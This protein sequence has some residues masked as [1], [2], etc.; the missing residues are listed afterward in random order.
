M[1][2]A[3]RQQKKCVWVIFRQPSMTGTE[4]CPTGCSPFLPVGQA[5][6][7]ADWVIFRQPSMTGTEACPDRHG[8]LS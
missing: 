4:A 2:F 1:G 3:G 8:G 6:L 5:S 7:S